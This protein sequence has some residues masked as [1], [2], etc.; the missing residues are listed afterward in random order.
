MQ[1]NNRQAY[2]RANIA[3]IRNL[4]IVWAIVSIGFSILLVQPLNTIRLG[5]VPLGFW[6]AQQGSIYVFV[7]LIFIYASQMD[8]LDRKYLRNNT[9]QPDQ[10]S[11]SIE[12]P[13]SLHR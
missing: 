11:D 8:R 10:S 2:W 1:H 7:A 5:G 13:S 12:P 4:L 9:V 3:L 6:L